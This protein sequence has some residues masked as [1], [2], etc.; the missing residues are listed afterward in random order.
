M[1]LSFGQQLSISVS[2]FYNSKWTKLPAQNCRSIVFIPSIILILQQR[3]TVSLLYTLGCT[4]VRFYV[5]VCAHSVHRQLMFFVAVVGSI[6]CCCFLL[7]SQ[8]L[9]L[10]LYL[11]WFDRS[12]ASSLE[13]FEGIYSILC[14]FLLKLYSF[15]VA[16]Y[17]QVP[18]CLAI[19]LND[20]FI[21]YFQSRHLRCFIL[22]PV[23]L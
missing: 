4:V 9:A 22:G 13:Y 11:I 1:L 17:C 10:S 3:V 18:L 15:I 20:I 16:S 21:F 2:S 12:D 14:Q 8:T 5:H 7:I 6:E 19:S 23:S